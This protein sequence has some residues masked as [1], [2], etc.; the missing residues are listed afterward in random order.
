TGQAVVTRKT[1]FRVGPGPQYD[2]LATVSG[3]TYAITGKTPDGSYYRLDYN[4]QDA[5][6]TAFA[7]T[8]TFNVVAAPTQADVSSANV[9]LDAKLTYNVPVD[10][11]LDRNQKTDFRFVGIAGETISIVV[12]DQ[13]DSLLQIYDPQNN[14]LIEDDHSGSNG[15]PRIDNLKLPRNGEYHVVLR[16]NTARDTGTFRLTVYKGAAPAAKS[17][18][19]I[20]YGQK[21]T[22]YFSPNSQ[23]VRVFDGKKGEVISIVVQANFSSY[24][25]LQDSNKNIVT[26]DD[27]SGI[28]GNPLIDLF[29][30]P[31]DGQYRIV[32]FGVN[33]NDAGTYSITLL[34]SVSGTMV[35]I[36]P[37][38]PVT[39]VLQRGDKAVFSFDASAGDKVTVTVDGKFNARISLRD[40]RG[41]ELAADGDG[42]SQAG[43]MDVQLADKGT[44][45][46]LV[47]GPTGSEQG[48]FTL[49]MTKR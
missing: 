30:L 49:T 13:F 7:Q 16:G 42:T 47:T 31:A 38:V 15:T 41:A 29:E 18:T 26:S 34:K 39:G 14:M 12:E 8:V 5:W 23:A 1:T 48:T 3:G 27:G 33:P 35:A 45:Y 21:I 11:K 36:K 32:L 25:Q 40:E 24:I 43:L 10:G 17:D 44:Y 19:A 28:E 2:V 20:K 6:V 46:I 9:P 22:A 4:G 37:G